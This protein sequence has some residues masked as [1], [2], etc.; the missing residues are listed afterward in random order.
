MPSSTSIPPLS[1]QARCDRYKACEMP[2]LTEPRVPCGAGVVGVVS[3]LTEHLQ[4]LVE[5]EGKKDRFE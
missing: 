5:S 2:R 3:R 1:R 4:V